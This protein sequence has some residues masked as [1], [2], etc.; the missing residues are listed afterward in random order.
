MG[1]SSEGGAPAATPRRGAPGWADGR[2]CVSQ[3]RD[4][5]ESVRTR[6]EG[7]GDESPSSALSLSLA[8]GLRR[9]TADT[10]HTGDV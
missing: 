9:R 4:T 5:G 6:R 10:R 8:G 1:L 3:G 7:G 2:V